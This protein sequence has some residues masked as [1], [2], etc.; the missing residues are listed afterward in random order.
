MLAVLD[1]QKP[2]GQES[3][4]YPGQDLFIKVEKKTA[5]KITLGVFGLCGF[6]PADTLEILSLD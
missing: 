5:N 4:K 2:P 3:A 6:I 1:A